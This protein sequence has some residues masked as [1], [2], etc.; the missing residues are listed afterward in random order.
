[1][2]TKIII[3]TILAILLPFS[4]V[5]AANLSGVT[6]KLTDDNK[7]FVISGTLDSPAEELI[8]KVMEVGK[9]DVAP[10]KVKAFITVDMY[11]KND[12]SQTLQL[13]DGLE[14]GRYYIYLSGTGITP[15]SQPVEVWYMDEENKNILINNI[16]SATTEALHK[17]SLFLDEENIYG[18]GKNYDPADKLGLKGTLYKD[19]YD[20]DIS[21][22]LYNKKTLD[23]STL[24][25]N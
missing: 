17:D 5:F 10:A 24:K 18:D 3:S 7:G 2:K 8:I 15:P 16:Y 12:F 6:A 14:S 23:Y 9:T 13:K 22:I 19:S 25:S 4:S 11:R 21:K 20:A 1:M